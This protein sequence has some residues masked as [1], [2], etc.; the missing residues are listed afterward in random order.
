MMFAQRFGGRPSTIEGHSENCCLKKIQ[1]I[2]RI[3]SELQTNKDNR[4]AT[5]TN[6]SIKN[7]YNVVRR[8]T[9]R[10]ARDKRRWCDKKTFRL[11]RCDRG[12]KLFTTVGGIK[13]QT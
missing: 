1:P 4:I 9:S 7:D 5:K 2:D 10:V 3:I 11:N 6:A 12:R 13:P 8:L